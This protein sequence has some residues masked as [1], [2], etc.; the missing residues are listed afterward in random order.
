MSA[1]SLYTVL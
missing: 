1:L